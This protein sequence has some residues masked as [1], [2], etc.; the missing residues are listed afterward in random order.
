[1][2]DRVPSMELIRQAHRE[3]KA[4][5]SDYCY[6]VPVEK[7]ILIPTVPDTLNNSIVEE[8]QRNFNKS[9]N[10]DYCPRID[11]GQDELSKSHTNPPSE[12]KSAD[13][14]RERVN[15]LIKDVQEIKQGFRPGKYLAR[16]SRTGATTSTEFV[17]VQ[18]R[19]EHKDS[20]TTMEAHGEENITQETGKMVKGTFV[21][22]GDKR[23]FDSKKSSSNCSF[24]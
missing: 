16:E 5:V 6:S 10:E 19:L 22:L 4:K 12:R 11:F 2:H 8:S 18:P 14:Y 17:F 20:T 1:M 15:R 21:T 9:P 24:E 3:I 13:K 7:N 23:Y